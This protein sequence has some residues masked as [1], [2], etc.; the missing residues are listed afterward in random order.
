MAGP[1]AAGKSPS[2]AVVPSL[3]IQFGCPKHVLDQL[4]LAITCAVYRFRPTSPLI[5]GPGKVARDI[6]QMIV[7]LDQ[8]AVD[9]SVTSLQ[10]QFVWVGDHRQNMHMWLERTAEGNLGVAGRLAQP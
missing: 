6:Q 7:R 5:S 10:T 2:L 9:F 8:G 4:S 3:Q 1:G